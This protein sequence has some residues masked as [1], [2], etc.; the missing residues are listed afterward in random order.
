MLIPVRLATSGETNM[1][2]EEMLALDILFPPPSC[3]FDEISRGPEQ[4]ECSR[5]GFGKELL[6]RTGDHSQA[7]FTIPAALP[8]EPPFHSMRS[9][10]LCGAPTALTSRSKDSVCRRCASTGPDLFGNI[11]IDQVCSPYLTV[12]LAAG[13][14]AMPSLESARLCDVC[15]TVVCKAFPAK[16][17]G[18][19]CAAVSNLII[20]YRYLR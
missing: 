8:A 13:R 18:I 20:D 11:L 17:R 3:C 6:H 14:H 12:Y 16:I 19:S 7:S 5:R 2:P 4:V 15:R 9:S 10:A 1:H